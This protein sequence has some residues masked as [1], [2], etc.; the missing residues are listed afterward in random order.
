MKRGF[1]SPIQ[2]GGLVFTFHVPRN[3]VFTLGE[4][5]KPQEGI[6][7]VYPTFATAE[8]PL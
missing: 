7:K 4:G 2:N 5:E 8:E 6:K 3:V 1:I